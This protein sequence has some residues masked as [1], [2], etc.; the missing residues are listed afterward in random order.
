MR[1]S[2]G[3]TIDY[4]HSR[5]RHS[6]EG[7]KAALPKLFPDGMPKSILDVG[8]GLGPWL[9]AA[10]DCGATDVFG[11]DGVDI[12]PE[13]LHF[14]AHRFKKCDL[15]A[16]IDLERQFDAVFCL[17]VAEHL[18]EMFASV[19][20]GTLTRHSDT[21]IFSA[22]CPEQDGQHHVNCQ[23]PAYWQAL[24]NKNGYICCDEVRWRIWDD[25]RI[26]PWYRQNMFIA[27]RSAD[28]AGREPRIK[29]IL[30][31]EMLSSYAGPENKL[32]ESHVRQIESGSM[33]VTWYWKIPAFGLL[34][35]LKK[36]LP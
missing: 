13:K 2:N 5:N 33:S 27:R 31:P 1:L 9:R 15:T 7:P 19:L 10:L 34:N 6:L 23:W 8:C 11:I 4:D 20:V 14:A 35:K 29:A 36:H 3:M 32:F 30:H 17:E 22:A 26:E 24:F 16:L 28:F 25:I 12:P 21:I 18:E